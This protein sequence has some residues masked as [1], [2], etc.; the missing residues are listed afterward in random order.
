MY[1]NE[2]QNLGLSEKEAKVY[3]T[4]LE[5]GPDTVQNIAK[6]SGINRATTYVQIDSLKEKGLMS[7]FEKGKKT[8][9][10]AESPEV[11]TN[12]INKE[13]VELNFKKLELGRVVPDL[14]KFY[15]KI[16]SSTEKPKIRFFEGEE[17]VSQIRADFLKT[18]NE[19]VYGFI[20]LDQVL[21][22]FVKNRDNYTE[23]RVSKKIYSKLIYTKKTGRYDNEIEKD[24][25]REMRYVKPDKFPF[26]ADISIY[27]DK[28]AFISYKNDA[29]GVIIEN[30]P[31]A[32]TMKA[33]FNAI[34]ENSK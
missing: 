27:R 8:Y 19:T 20:N 1:E 10:V 31:I 11:L 15:D 4:S 32:E 28:V 2:L 22:K 13:E 3:T 17:G 12:L 6:A 21:N 18:Q 25:L 23:K 29:V 5:L 14:V 16:S 24:K 26:D 33:I 34:W 7:E 9:Y 30:K